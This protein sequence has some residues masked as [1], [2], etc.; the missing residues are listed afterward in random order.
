[1]KYLWDAMGNNP[2]DDVKQAVGG[3]E[4]EGHVPDPYVILD[5]GFW[6]EA[7]QW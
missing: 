2:I 4:G 7:E 6:G 3:E 5:A 1:M